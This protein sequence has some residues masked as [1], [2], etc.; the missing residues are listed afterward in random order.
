MNNEY[1]KAMAAAL[2]VGLL[3][4]P[5]D[6]K[7]D[8]E[9]DT[10]FGTDGYVLIDL[11][12]SLTGVESNILADLLVQPDGRL[13]LVG[14]VEYP[15]GARELGIARLTSGGGL[16][17]SFGNSGRVL[18]VFDPTDPSPRDLA[19][20]AVL[21]QNGTIAV[22]AF[23]L[24]GSDILDGILRLTLTGALDL[25]FAPRGSL[26]YPIYV[27]NVLLNDLSNFG[28]DLEALGGGALSGAEG[29][30][31]TTID[32]SGDSGLLV[33]D[34]PAGLVAQM[35]SMSGLNASINRYYTGEI[36]SDGDRDLGLAAVNWLFLAP[37]TSFGEDAWVRVRA[38]S[39][40]GDWDSGGRTV[41]VY[42][43]NR[44]VAGGW[45][46][47]NGR[48]GF[49]VRVLSDG[50]PDPSFGVAGQQYVAWNMGG[51][52]EDIVHDIGVQS[53]GYLVLAATAENAAV[54]PPIIARLD[55][56]GNY[57][58]NFASNGWRTLPAPPNHVLSGEP[59]IALLPDGNIAVA[60]LAT[61]SSGGP[62]LIYVTRLLSTHHVFS[63]GFE[64]G[65]ASRW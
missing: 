5:M 21:L 12:A 16:D 24:D 2:V 38:E 8:G 51:G 6:G 63:D 3:M 58:A 7:A 44:V 55:S 64:S 10:S 11:G 39:A 53:D 36:F 29:V 15:G 47:R 20:A 14:S 33:E 25:D 61:P 1:S 17:A 22:G 54:Y 45:A 48:D 43:G 31:S 42:P 23:T 4:F 56:H 35:Y 30:V 13:V 41:A 49:V 60:A 19:K 46:D 65:D 32:S 28:H 50:S 40:G 34:P 62:D 37:D 57:D 9:V 59:Q 26:T 27:G 18:H 52:D